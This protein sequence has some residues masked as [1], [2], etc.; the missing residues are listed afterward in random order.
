MID[1]WCSSGKSFNLFY[2]GFKCFSGSLISTDKSECV[3]KF[4]FA[5]AFGLKRNERHVYPEIIIISFRRSFLQ[6]VPSCLWYKLVCYLRTLLSN[7]ATNLICH[8]HIGLLCV[9]ISFGLCRYENQLNLNGS[10]I[11]TG[12]NVSAVPTTCHGSIEDVNITG[13]DLG[14]PSGREDTMSLDIFTHFD[15]LDREFDSDM[16]TIFLTCTSLRWLHVA[17]SHE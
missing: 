1:S 5:S 7:F 12:E 3:A 8:D 9:E 11:G 10:S 2:H 15:F 6:I 14:T 16:V 13:L 17:I 4:C